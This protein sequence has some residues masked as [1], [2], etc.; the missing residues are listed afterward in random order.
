VSSV[1]IFQ[2]PMSMQ[3]AFGTGLAL[4]GVFLYSQMKRKYK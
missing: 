2:N 3:N 4:A 1:I